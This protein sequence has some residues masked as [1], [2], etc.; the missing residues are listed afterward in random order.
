MD[1]AIEQFIATLHPELAEVVLSALELLEIF[2]SAF[3][4]LTFIEILGDD[5]NLDSNAR[6]DSFFA[7]LVARLNGVLNAHKLELLND[8]PLTT[9]V[10]ILQTFSDIQDTTDHATLLSILE[11]SCDPNEVLAELVY[12]F[13]GTDSSS[14]MESIDRFDKETIASFNLDNFTLISE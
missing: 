1:T 4:Q 12:Y 3:E 2:E 7:E 13:T 10:A 8:A 9:R 11:A 6:H 14:V 5:I